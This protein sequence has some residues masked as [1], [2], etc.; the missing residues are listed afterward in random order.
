MASPDLL[1]ELNRR[2]HNHRALY[3]PV[4]YQSDSS[5]SDNSWS[6]GNSDKRESIIPKYDVR[7]GYLAA[8]KVERFPIS[9][10][11]RDPVFAPKSNGRILLK[12]NQDVL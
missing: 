1:E 7:R 3:N 4:R 10:D 9:R 12:M 6:L 11:L 2:I 8:K 5:K